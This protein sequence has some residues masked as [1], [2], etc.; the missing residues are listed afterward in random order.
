MLTSYTVDLGFVLIVWIMVMLGQH[1][2][3][4]FVMVVNVHLFAMFMKVSMVCA[5]FVVQNNKIDPCIRL[6]SHK[7]NGVTA[8]Y[9]FNN[10][11]LSKVML[12]GKAV[13]VF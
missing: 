12:Y 5:R 7:N 3:H 9:T 10:N 6:F 2:I 4:S 13:T 11:H 8:R 1:R